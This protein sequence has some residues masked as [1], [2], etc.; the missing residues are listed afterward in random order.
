MVLLQ[1]ALSFLLA[2]ARISWVQSAVHDVEHLERQ[3]AYLG[4]S[5]ADHGRRLGTTDP[6]CFPAHDLVPQ[7]HVAPRSPRFALLV[8]TYTDVASPT[9]QE[10]AKFYQAPAVAN[11]IATVSSGCVDVTLIPIAVPLGITEKDDS[12]SCRITHS[13]DL[14]TVDLPA[15]PDWLDGVN[16]KP[17][18][19]GS[20][21]MPIQGTCTTSGGAGTQKLTV[22]GTTIKFSG[23]YFGHVLSQVSS[24]N[25]NRN[26]EGIGLFGGQTTYI[27]ELFH[28][29]GFAYHSNSYE[30]L[31][32]M[33]HPDVL[34]CP[35][36]EYGDLYDVMGTGTG[37]LKGFHARGRYHM[38]W[39]G[40]DNITVIQMSG[41]YT[42]GPINQAGKFS[43]AAVVAGKD[44][45]LEYR[46]MS[47]TSTE[48]SSA[49]LQNLGLFVRHENKLIDAAL[50]NCAVMD[51]EAWME[52]LRSVTLSDGRALILR[53]LGIIIGDIARTSSAINFSV[54]F[55]GIQAGCKHELP[56]ISE[57][58]WGEWQYIGVDAKQGNLDLASALRGKAPLSSYSRST[59]HLVNTMK[60]R[61]G[62]GCQS[63]DLSVVLASELPQGWAFAT[64]VP[65]ALKPG[66][67]Q[68]VVFGFGIPNAAAD[69][70]Y[71]FC[72]AVQ[73][74]SGL[75]VAKLFRLT[76]P[77]KNLKWYTNNRPLSSGVDAT[78]RAACEAAQ[79]CAESYPS[80]SEPVRSCSKE[81]QCRNTSWSAWGRCW[82]TGSSGVRFRGKDFCNV[83]QSHCNVADSASILMQ[84]TCDD[85]AP[86]PCL[87]QHTCR[88]NGNSWE[89]MKSGQS[90]SVCA[91]TALCSSSG[92]GFGDP[93]C[94][95]FWSSG[96]L[97]GSH[98]CSGNE[99]CIRAICESSA[100]CGGYQK[101][102]T[103]STIWLYP[104]TLSA[105]SS[106]STDYECWVKPDTAVKTCSCFGSEPAVIPNATQCG[107]EAAPTST[108][109]PTPTLAPMP[110]QTP[111][112]TPAPMPRL[113]LVPTPAPL[114][115]PMLAPMSVQTPVPTPVSTAA[116]PASLPTP[117]PLPTPK[118]TP[119]GSVDACMDTKVYTSELLALTMMLW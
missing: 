110:V 11:F 16:V 66:T 40:K 80:C 102:K 92:D 2:V 114:P 99:T 73:S 43:R 22:Q 116:L 87:S 119:P 90:S 79:G 113:T 54:F 19:H 7:L 1:A 10:V 60:N 112:P 13:E 49:L 36:S 83:Q 117:T 78:V 98:V 6:P 109:A 77:E 24:E 64:G 4:E 56:E 29:L 100:K 111:V 35:S 97:K 59:V 42:I 31:D 9:P 46:T 3:A 76:L 8:M 103:S 21:I 57:G 34:G 82:G 44:L 41:T 85:A 70:D 68:S 89:E 48:N 67:S 65:V 115:A 55:S 58:L 15:L 104:K 94:D 23:I 86:F 84:E 95:N 88:V 74:S 38:G 93:V 91:G 52:E 47:D 25:R 5:D 12:G 28:H 61:D 18:F 51:S 27:H 106:P 101:S 33:A 118:S 30:C 39:L 53:A 26:G 62:S 20:I 63:S 37:Y 81:L 72:V 69:G 14:G 75:R 107:M 108:P 96:D 50:G 17:E 32:P 71:D 45:W 105:S